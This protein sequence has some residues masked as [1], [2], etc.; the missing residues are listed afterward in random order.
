MVA[1][2]SSPGQPE[3]IA[4][5]RSKPAAAGACSA[6][7]Q[8]PATMLRAMRWN[9]ESR[10]DAT[11]TL[12]APSKSALV[13]LRSTSKKRID[14]F[15]SSAGCGTRYAKGIR[16]KCVSEASQSAIGVRSLAVSAAMSASRSSWSRSSLT[17]AT[18]SGCGVEPPASS[19]SFGGGAAFDSTAT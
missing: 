18:G 17:A 14:S 11:P 2:T 4:E 10:L 15:G 1:A 6:L 5:R 13:H 19:G 12:M 3:T 9:Q 8:A 7:R 16:W